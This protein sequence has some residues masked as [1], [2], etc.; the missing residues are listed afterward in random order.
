MPRA[1]ASATIVSVR[2][3]SK[4]PGLT[5]M[6]SHHTYWRTKPIPAAAMRSSSVRASAGVGLIRSDHV[7]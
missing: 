1:E 7:P 2:L 5:S 6:R 3:Q 4:V